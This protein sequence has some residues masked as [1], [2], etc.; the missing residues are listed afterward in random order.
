MRGLEKKILLALALLSFIPASASGP[1]LGYGQNPEQAIYSDKPSER[2]KP[3]VRIDPGHYPN[4]GTSYV[5]GKN[6][7]AE[8]GLTLKVGELV[9]SETKDADVELTREGND[10]SEKL[11][12]F[13]ASQSGQLDLILDSKEK[14]A[15]KKHFE[16]DRERN[17]KLYAISLYSD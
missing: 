9:R 17:A 11:K 15:R 13:R 7:L 5:R 14:Y 12:S 4:N 10:Y 3:K 8:H 16:F 2:K 1:V 6:S